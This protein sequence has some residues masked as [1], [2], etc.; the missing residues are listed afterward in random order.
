M[1]CC[2]AIL[3]ELRDPTSDMIFDHPACSLPSYTDRTIRCRSSWTS[4]EGFKAFRPHRPKGLRAQQ[5]D[6]PSKPSNGKTLRLG[7]A[8]QLQVWCI[9][10]APD[11]VPE[12]FCVKPSSC[13]LSGRLPPLEKAAHG[14]G[15][16][17]RPF[18]LQLRV[19][20]TGWGGHVV[21]H[22]TR[23]VIG[24]PDRNDLVAWQVL[25]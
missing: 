24:V 4:A 6:L 16:T 22:V 11:S 10:H 1:T 15:S 18:E 5:T 23:R 8:P 3:A 13:Q 12:S 21:R 17:A 14:Q 7:A 20:A 2:R 19:E 9:C 25:D